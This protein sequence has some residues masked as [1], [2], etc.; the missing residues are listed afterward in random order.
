MHIKT[1]KK[2]LR[3]TK[4]RIIKKLLLNSHLKGNL[5]IKMFINSIQFQGITMIQ[6]SLSMLDSHFL[7]LE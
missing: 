5:F 2:T 4:S 3:N 1:G 6:R 7:S